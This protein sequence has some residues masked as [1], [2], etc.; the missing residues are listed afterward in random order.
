ML[1]SALL[2]FGLS[3]PMG[4]LVAL[5]VLFVSTY[6]VALLC[7]AWYPLALWFAA[8][9]ILRFFIKVNLPAGVPDLNAERILLL[10]AI[11][12]IAPRLFECG[13]RLRSN[14][15]FLLPTAGL[16]LYVLLRTLSIRDS[17]AGIAEAGRLALNGVWVPFFLYLLTLATVCRREQMDDLMR[18]VIAVLALGG[19][20]GIA[21]VLLN[22]EQNIMVHLG[23]GNDETYQ[24]WHSG[25][26]R[27]AAGPFANPATLGGVA[28]LASLFA[29]RR[30]LEV[31]TAPGATALMTWSA[32]C[33]FFCMTRGPWVATLAGHLVLL[34][35]TRRLSVMVK[36]LMVAVLFVGPLLVGTARHL[37]KAQ[38]RVHDQGTIYARLALADRGLQMISESP[39]RGQGMGAFNAL[40]NTYHSALANPQ[41]LISHN[42]YITTAVDSGLVA[43]AP[44]FFAIGYLLRQGWQ[45]AKRTNRWGRGRIA[46]LMGG[47]TLFLV[48]GMFIDLTHANY[49]G[50]LL[51]CLMGMLIIE[52]GLPRDKRATSAPRVL[53]LERKAW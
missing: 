10:F 36:V 9:P 18:A 53:A 2:G 19:A 8:A 50:A 23:G 12:A 15:T 28:G 49:D 51:L 13:V 42:T 7:P 20:L 52:L 48:Q 41:R 14:A 1:A 26:L 43:L 29:H 11:V 16:A 40:N 21:E 35:V 37:E 4:G 46:F 5:G 39:G 47:I 32:L 31:K 38:Q 17:P 33:L 25:G 22:L 44:L 6:A 45:R 24:V 34:S 27:R 3:S 30:L